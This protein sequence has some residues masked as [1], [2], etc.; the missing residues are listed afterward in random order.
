MSER[1]RKGVCVPKWL[2]RALFVEWDIGLPDRCPSFS[3]KEGQF[4]VEQIDAISELNLGRFLMNW[5]A[6]R[7]QVKNS[8][9]T[10][11]WVE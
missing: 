9:F 11:T 6:W 1:D 10:T 3:K 2:K 7:C 5:E 8:F 4:P